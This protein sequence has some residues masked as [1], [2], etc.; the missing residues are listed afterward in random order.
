MAVQDF[1]DLIASDFQSII[2][3]IG[4]DVTLNRFTQVNSNIT[5]EEDVDN[6]YGSNVTIRG[7]FQ[8]NE[9]THSLDREGIFE[10]A[11]AV[12]YCKPADNVQKD[13]KITFESRI[14]LVR[15]KTKRNSVDMCPLELWTK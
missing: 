8:L 15:S 5:G 4:T 6:S 7:V 1:N 13:D 12:L 11:D 9:R 2:D 3:E 14:Y 10:G